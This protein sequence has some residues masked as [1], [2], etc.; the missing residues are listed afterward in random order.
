MNTFIKPEKYAEINILLRRGQDYTIPFTF[1]ES[2]EGPAMD[3][4]DRTFECVTVLDTDDETPLL[5]LPVAVADAMGGAITI[6]VTRAQTD[7]NAVMPRDHYWRLWMTDTNGDRRLS[8]AGI[9][10]MEE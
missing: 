9:I 4:T 6:R 2:E 8:V 10:R 3:L 1:R 5:T 7:D